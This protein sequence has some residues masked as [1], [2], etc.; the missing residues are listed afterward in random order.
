MLLLRLV[1]GASWLFCRILLQNEA[2]RVEVS[3][4]IYWVYQSQI[5]VQ[6]YQ[7]N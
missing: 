6:M 4:M 7:S 1:L 5:I 2:A 3:I